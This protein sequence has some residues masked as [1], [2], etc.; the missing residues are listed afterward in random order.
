MAILVPLPNHLL[1]RDLAHE[2]SILVLLDVEVLQ[3]LYDLQL[4][5]CDLGKKKTAFRW[6]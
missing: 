2:N 4:M 3:I 5:F 1:Q 6:R